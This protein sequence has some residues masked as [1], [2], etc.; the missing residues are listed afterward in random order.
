MSERYFGISWI[1]VKDIPHKNGLSKKSA[2]KWQITALKMT[3]E[4]DSAPSRVRVPAHEIQES[5]KVSSL[6]L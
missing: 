4:S 1:H 5:M 3:S 6:L 2:T